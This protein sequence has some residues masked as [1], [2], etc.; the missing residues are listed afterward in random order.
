MNSSLK[1]LYFAIKILFVGMVLGIVF[2]AFQ[3]L[4]L[5]HSY[6]LNTF[7]FRG[8]MFS[9]FY[10]VLLSAAKWN[11]Y[12]IWSVYFPFTYVIFHPLAALRK[13]I[14]LAVFI[15]ISLSGI[16]VAI[17]QILR[18]AMPTKRQAVE[19]AGLLIGLSYPIW[20]CL[21]R[22]NIEIGLLFLICGF[23]LMVKRGNF[24]TGLLFIVPAICMKFY[25][26][27][28]LALFIRRGQ[29]KYA[30]IAVFLFLFTTFISLT[31]FDHTWIEDLHLW[32]FQ[33]DKFK[34]VYI[35]GNGSMGG[36]ASIWNAAKLVLFGWLFAVS[37]NRDLFPGVSALTQYTAP[38]LS[39]YLASMILFAGAVTW[40]VAIVEKQF[41]RR[42]IV[43]G[44]FMV[45]APQGGADYKLIHIL[46][47]LAVAI[48]IITRRKHDWLIVGLL[49]FVLLPKKYWFFPQIVTDSGCSDCSIAVLINPLLMLT[50]LTFICIDG[51]A[52]STANGRRFRG[53]LTLPSFWFKHK[54]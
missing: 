20:F 21:Q 14:V 39:I 30:G 34:S 15:I 18:P 23:L 26:A 49:A 44:L 54:P 27:V 17:Y 13:N 9:D 19:G 31:F 43:L 22:G 5:H 53:N 2:H 24:W 46:A 25:P 29:F 28:F 51:W 6:P 42:V 37:G 45:L 3:G 4:L 16:W 50:A 10:E 8:C 52:S 41:W 47:L 35:I 48:A 40:Y 1:K 33:L 32:Q 12:S 7:L 11:P 36:S 38:L